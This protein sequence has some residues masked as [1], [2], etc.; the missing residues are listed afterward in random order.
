MRRRS[1]YRFS[2]PRAIPSSCSAFSSLQLDDHTNQS[3]CKVSTGGR[4][5]SGAGPEY[6]QPGSKIPKSHQI[7][8][9][10]PAIGLVVA[11]VTHHGECTRHQKVMYCISYHRGCT[12]YSLAGPLQVAMGSSLCFAWEQISETSR[13]N[14]PDQLPLYFS[15]Y[16]KK[17]QFLEPLDPG[18]FR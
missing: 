13:I 17:F 15:L 12:A 8:I 9:W 3:P 2:R 5:G 4:C 14:P 1:E 7:T 6:S 11:G 10:A 16:A 18:Q